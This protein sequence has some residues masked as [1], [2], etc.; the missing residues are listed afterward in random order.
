MAD[1]VTKLTDV[2]VPELFSQYV[3]EKTKEKSELIA[4]GA[5]ESNPLLDQL[6]NGGGNTMKMPKWNDLTGESQVFSESADIET[7]KIT[8]H[9]EIATLLL[10]ARGWSAHD[11]SAALAGD[12]PMQR[13]A[14][15]VADW[16]VR[17]EKRIVMS[18]L[19]G[20]FASADMADHVL[21][22]TGGVTTGISAK[23]I[24]DAKQL[25]GDAAED[26]TLIYMHSAVYTELQKQ[27]LIT[28][29]QPADAKVKMPTYLGYN[30]ICDDSAPV[31]IGAGGT[32]GVYTVTLTG[33]VTADDVITVAGVAHT[34]TAAEDT[35]AKIAAGIAADL[36]ATVAVTNVFTVTV[37]EAV[38]TF[39]QKVAGTGAQP[40]ASVSAS[41]TETAT[42]ATTTSGVAGVDKFTTYLLSRGCIQ[43]G[44]GTPVGFVATETFRNAKKS[45]DELYNRQAKVLHPKGMNWTSASQE[46]ETPSNAELATGANWTRA[47]AES[48]QVGMIALVHTL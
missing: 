2:I 21:D 8:A 4:S 6:V 20:V 26:L 13:I 7:D 44:S 32:K 9:K 40:T 34:V 39:T 35:L 37:A 25:M 11:L 42:A 1:K 22:I 30:V 10:R 27:Q 47:A 24:L 36:N 48:K 18:I 29:V 16:W 19:K 15:R 33:T 28:F 3:L 5:I 14:E 45:V 38:I 43:R 46:D 31:E 23:A 12:D 41:A 17:D